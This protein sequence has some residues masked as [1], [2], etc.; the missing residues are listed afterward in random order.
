MKAKKVYLCDISFYRYRMRSDSI[1]NSLGEKHYISL[2]I[3]ADTLYDLKQIEK[4]NKIYMDSYL[5]SL[6]YEASKYPEILCRLDVEKYINSCKRLTINACLK[7]VLLKL[8][9]Y[10]YSK[11]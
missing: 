10:N 8:K 6:V 3:I 2:S 5:L 4:I 9:L 1:M 11:A 7:K